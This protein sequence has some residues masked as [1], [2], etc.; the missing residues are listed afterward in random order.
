MR[1]A[2][3]RGSNSQADTDHQCVKMQ[4]PKEPRGASTTAAVAWLTRGRSLRKGEECGS[5]LVVYPV[6]FGHYAELLCAELSDESLP[7]D[8]SPHILI[9][10]VMARND[11][12]AYKPR[13]MLYNKNFCLLQKPEDL[14]ILDSHMQ[15][16]GA[17]SMP[18][19]MTPGSG[20]GQFS[21]L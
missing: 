17:E 12:L 19:I 5:S 7:F 9:R 21:S 15:Y 20:T 14:K 4:G 11:L 13:N 3:L 16:L 10:T 8:P 2:C 6:H 1:Y 18:V